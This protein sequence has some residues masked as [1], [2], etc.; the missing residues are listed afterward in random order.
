MDYFVLFGSGLS[1]FPTLRKA[2]NR[3]RS[4]VDT[5]Q[6][7]AVAE[8][9]SGAAFVIQRDEVCVCVTSGYKCSTQGWVQAV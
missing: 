9:A 2:M 3:W 1:Q 5:K 7:L 4:I 6:G 8:D